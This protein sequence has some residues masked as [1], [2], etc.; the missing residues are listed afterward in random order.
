MIILL[1]VEKVFGK[2]EYPS[3]I[4]AMNK[5]GLKGTYLDLIKT[6]I[7]SFQLTSH[8]MEKS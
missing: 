3:M 7:K 6:Y 8:S 5:P 4:K 1:D 2:F